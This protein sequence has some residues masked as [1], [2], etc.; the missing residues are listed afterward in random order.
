MDWELD[1]FDKISV[2]LTKNLIFGGDG[3]TQNVARLLLHQ[4][5]EGYGC[6]VDCAS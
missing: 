2:H 4:W 3:E 5:A 1:V 6:R